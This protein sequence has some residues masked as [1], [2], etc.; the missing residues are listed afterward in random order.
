MP[1]FRTH[2]VAAVLGG[3]DH[4]FEHYVEHYTDNTGV[5]RMDLIISA[6]GG[7]PL[8]AYT[9]E[10]DTA[11]YLAAGASAKV[12]LDH[13]VK[14]L[15]VATDNKFH[16]TILRVDGNKLSIEVVGLDAAAAFKPYGK[17]VFD[18]RD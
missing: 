5:H 16:F 4:E 10:P 12:Q 14:P 6:G 13:I 2:H 18:L 3:H 9:G 8:Y 15:P 7:A 11:D 17:D 1:L